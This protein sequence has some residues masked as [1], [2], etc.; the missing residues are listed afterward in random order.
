MLY[1]ALVALQWAPKVTLAYLGM[2]LLYGISIN[3][4]ILGVTIFLDLFDFVPLD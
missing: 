2:T 3:N 4:I 1:Q